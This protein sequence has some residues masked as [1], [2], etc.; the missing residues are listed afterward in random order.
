MPSNK[1]SSKKVSLREFIDKNYHLF[2]TIGAVAALSALFTR[3]ENAE[4]LAFLS[5]AML[6]L[7]NWE[8][9][10]AFPKSEEASLILTVFEYIFQFFFIMVGVYVCSAYTT[11]ILQPL[12]LF[13]IL[14][15]L[16][17]GIFIVFFKKFKLY[18]HVR[19]IAPEGKR[20]SPLIRGAV[21]FAIILIALI[22]AMLVAKY[23]TGLVKI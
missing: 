11:F 4:Y 9:W 13:S 14:L 18:K 23:I 12:I 8:L 19:K 5:F 1:K 6:I 15:V 17:A 7:L 21:A 20:Y 22:L 3:L 16:F 2:T 10:V